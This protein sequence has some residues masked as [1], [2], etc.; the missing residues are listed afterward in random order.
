[1]TGLNK[2]TT[3]AYIKA[4]TAYANA[5]AK[6][7]SEIESFNSD[8]RGVEGFVV[9]IILIAIAAIFAII[10]KDAIAVWLDTLV[11]KINSIFNDNPDESIEN[12]APSA[13]KWF[14]NN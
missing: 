12:A 6:I 4:T 5:K 10:F 3:L 2:L 9:A 1:M 11:K 13:I 7:K 8:E 14:L